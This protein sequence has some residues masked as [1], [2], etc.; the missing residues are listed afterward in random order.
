MKTQR[1]VIY[2]AASY[3]LWGFFPL[4]FKLLHT[5]PAFQI[6]AHRIVWSF[7]FLMILVSLRRELP[8]LKAALTPRILLVY[9]VAGLLLAVNWGTY[10]WAVNSNFVVEASLGYFINPLVSVL[11]GI[12]FFHER[13][14]PL[15][16]VPVGIALVGVV[17]LTVTYGSLPWIALAL[18]FSF[19]L[20]GLM[21]KLAPLGSLYGLTLETGSITLFALGFLVYSHVTGAGVF[22]N[23]GWVTSLLLAFTGVVT[24]IPLL[25]F[26]T[27]ARNVPLS[28]MGLLQ[29]ISPTIQFMCGVFV[30]GEHFTSTRLIGFAI[31][32]VALIFFSAESFLVRRQ[33]VAS[34]AA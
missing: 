8:V 32:W 21:K 18:A 15:Q 7:I 25:L 1:G 3:A 28:T 22:V 33:S 10:V 23:M 5:V 11:L 6:T 26:A 16:W 2:A 20:Y 4:Y 13:L 29:Y 27:G 34:A 12:I 31:I 30:F 14:R 19:G 17:Y 9:L 24:S